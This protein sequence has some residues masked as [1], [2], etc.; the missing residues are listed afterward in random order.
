M[1][2]SEI[3]GVFVRVKAV[4]LDS[5]VLMLLM[6]MVTELFS[7]FEA[8]PDLYR[9]LAFVLIFGLYDPILTSSVGGTIGHMV[10][11][12]RVKRD[13]HEGKN[14]LF[15]VAVV[16]FLVKATLG[17]ISLVTVMGHKQGKAIHDMVARSVVVY[18]TKNLKV[19]A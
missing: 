16:R 1:V 8:V 14:I 6:L 10:F 13:N 3:P 7:S 11:G 19:A 2:Q 12:L 5:F 4:V 17:W 18:H 15:P 9:I